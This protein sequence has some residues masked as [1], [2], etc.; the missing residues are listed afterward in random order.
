MF[1]KSLISLFL[2]TSSMYAFADGEK[3]GDFDSYKLA[4]TWAPGFCKENQS[5][6]ECQAL[7]KELKSDYNY[8]VTLHGLWPNV[9]GTTTYGNCTST[10]FNDYQASA[11]NNILMNYSLP[12]AK[13]CDNT[14]FCL[15][16]HEWNKH[17][18]CQL[19]WDQP[20]YFYVQSKML[21]LFRDTLVAPLENK[22]SVTKSELYSIILKQFPTKNIDDFDLIC[23]PDT[24]MLKEIR[25][26]LDK[27][28][29]D[30]SNDKWRSLSK[31][32]LSKH[33]I[34]TDNL[35][36]YCGENIVLR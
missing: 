6:Q 1:K 24:G 27:N 36:N 22:D 15:P 10:K 14:G 23:N 32:D 34:P 33:I 26:S 29:E 28:I 8:A 31:T 7:N 5:K 3:A 13:Y 17:G 25:V 30:I 21:N 11:F 12:A 19:K 2:I 4:I 35:S 18:T 20:E 9:N 16:E